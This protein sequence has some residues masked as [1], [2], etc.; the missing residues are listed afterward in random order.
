M[1]VKL[2]QD[3]ADAVVKALAERG[4][5]R[6]RI[7]AMG[8]GPYCPIDQGT[9]AAAYEKN[10]RVEFKIVRTSSGP[11]GIALG[12]DKATQKGITSPPP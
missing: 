6:Q 1:N 10:R 3:R 8:F 11:T 12:C 4:I 2:T 5:D 7:R 9:S